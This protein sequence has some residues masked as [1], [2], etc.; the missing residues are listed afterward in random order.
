LIPLYSAGLW[1]ALIMAPPSAPVS[2]QAKETPGVGIVPRARISA[3]AEVIPPSR[4]ASS[5]A[6]ERRVSRPTTILGRGTPRRS[7]RNST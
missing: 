7:R 5:M 1:E 4:E 6:P 2:R 3:P